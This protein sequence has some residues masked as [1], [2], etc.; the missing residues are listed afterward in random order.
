ML[1]KYKN[2]LFPV[3]V[4]ITALNYCEEGVHIYLGNENAP[5]IVLNTLHD[6][7]EIVEKIAGEVNR[8]TKVF[9]LSEVEI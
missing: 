6:G 9:D 2:Q 5:S 4:G 8:G 1:I 3:D 7:C